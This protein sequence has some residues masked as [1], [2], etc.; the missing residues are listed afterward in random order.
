M[1]LGAR[2]TKITS[3]SPRNR[4][5]LSFDFDQRISMSLIVKVGTRLNVNANTIPNRHLLSKFN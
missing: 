2:F 3:F 5:N 1:D 4:S